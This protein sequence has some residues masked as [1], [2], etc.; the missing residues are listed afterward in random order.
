MKVE[1][2]NTR[3]CII[4]KIEIKHKIIKIIKTKIIKLNTHKHVIFEI[5]KSYKIK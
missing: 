4:K 3:N 2:N 5:K 1:Y